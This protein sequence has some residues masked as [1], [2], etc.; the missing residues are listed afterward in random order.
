LKKELIYFSK[1]SFSQSTKNFSEVFLNSFLMWS[2]KPLLIYSANSY[3]CLFL[4][5]L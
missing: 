4:T 5:S 2:S 3:H 1:T